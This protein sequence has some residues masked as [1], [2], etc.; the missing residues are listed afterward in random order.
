MIIQSHNG[1]NEISQCFVHNV[2]VK[3]VYECTNTFKNLC[4][5]IETLQKRV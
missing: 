2:F 4:I 1:A 3:D 5:S